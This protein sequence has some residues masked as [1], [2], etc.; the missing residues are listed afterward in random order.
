MVYE[1]RSRTAALL[2]AI[3]VLAGCGSGRRTTT[4][5]RT[6]SDR[7]FLDRHTLEAQVRTVGSVLLRQHSKLSR[8]RP[9]VHIRDVTCVK[10]SPGD[11]VG[12]RWTFQ[13]RLSYSSG[14][15]KTLWVL[16][17]PDGSGWRVVPRPRQYV[18]RQ[19]RV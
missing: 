15:T 4:S 12:D 6:T 14:D 17:S 10:K 13:C 3:V 11:G 18:P 1:M 19:H 8:A 5:D 7:T 2:L 9:H 16:V